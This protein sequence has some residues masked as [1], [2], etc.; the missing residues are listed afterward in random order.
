MR[1]QFSTVCLVLALFATAGVAAQLATSL[2]VCVVANLNN[3]PTSTA[4]KSA[5]DNYNR[6]LATTYSK[7][8]LAPVTYIDTQGSAITAITQLQPLVANPPHVVILADNSANNNA[9]QA[10]LQQAG[11]AS[12]VVMATTNQG[13]MMLSSNPFTVRIQPSDA[14]VASATVANIQ[15]LG[16]DAFAVIQSSDAFAD[17]F[18]LALRGALQVPLGPNIVSTQRLSAFSNDVLGDDAALKAA[19]A[20]GVDLIVVIGET[21]TTKRVF[22]AITRLPGSSN[23]SNVPFVMI[24]RGGLLDLPASRPLRHG[25]IAS[26]FTKRAQLSLMSPAVLP[27]SST[28][29]EDVAF[30]VSYVLDALE[31]SMWAAT[32]TGGTTAQAMAT[33]MLKASL[34]LAF[35]GPLALD[36]NGD[37]VQD[38]MDFLQLSAVAAPSAAPLALSSW[39]RLTAVVPTPGVPKPPVSMSTT[40]VLSVCVAIPDTCSDYANAIHAL[41]VFLDAA[42]TTVPGKALL[43]GT[44]LLHKCCLSDLQRSTDWAELSSA[45]PSAASSWGPLAR[46]SPSRST[47]SFLTTA[48]QRWTILRRPPN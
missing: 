8:T 47:P 24:L 28:T 29:S 31:L 14:R 21:G 46:R 25:V 41:V 22:D 35:T 32:S 20:T 42:T 2:K 6:Q 40:T 5:M 23:A 13:N 4:L 18:T 15:Y 27:A 37:R 33:A 26:R 1:T 30:L 36:A 39:S 12:V 38:N 43:S 11:V 3:V 7:V 17:Y 10:A 34:P 16:V 9:I 44:R 45:L 48:S 19:I